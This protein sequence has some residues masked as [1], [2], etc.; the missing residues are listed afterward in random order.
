MEF[1]SFLSLQITMASLTQTPYTFRENIFEFMETW[2][3]QT[4][5]SFTDDITKFI[6]D[7]G[8]PL[9]QAS[10]E[11]FDEKAKR[12]E[13]IISKQ[14]EEIEQ[15]KTMMTPNQCEKWDL[16]IET[17]KK[18]LQ[19]EKIAHQRCKEELAMRCQHLKVIERK[20]SKLFD[21]PDDE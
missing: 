13:E 21:I 20:L 1:H 4:H 17:N 6:N 12:A 5:K 8:E 9:I 10:P 3:K 2:A 14:A 16:M 15:L 7:L 18:Q 11:S 19:D